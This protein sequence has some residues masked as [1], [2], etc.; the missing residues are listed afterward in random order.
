MEMELLN[1]PQGSKTRLQA[2]LR[3][4]KSELER[5]KQTLVQFE[6]ETKEG[7]VDFFP[8]SWWL[9]FSLRDGSYHS[10]PFEILVHRSELNQHP[11]Q[12]QTEM[13]CWAVS[14]E[15]WIW[16]QPR[17]TSALAS[18]PVLTA[19]Q[20]AADVCRTAT[21]LHWRLVRE[22]ERERRLS[23]GNEIYEHERCVYVF[24]TS[25]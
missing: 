11:A 24:C 18:W 5:V 13:N 6:R 22:I 16:M 9:K 17:W 1:L 7:A 21:R 8:N 23:R 10:Q 2:R 20:R 3:G 4:Y 12:P 14:V 25:I 19:L 15:A